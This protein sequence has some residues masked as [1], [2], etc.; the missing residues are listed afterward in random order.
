MKSTYFSALIFGAIVSMNVFSATFDQAAADSCMDDFDFNMGNLERQ[1]AKF[2][3]A[4]AENQPAEKLL[5]LMTGLNMYVYRLVDFAGIKLK[6]YGYKPVWWHPIQSIALTQLD[7]RKSGDV[8]RLEERAD[9]VLIDLKEIQ[10]ALRQTLARPGCVDDPACV[11]ETL[12]KME[13]IHSVA[14]RLFGFVN[15]LITEYV[16]DRFS[17]KIRSSR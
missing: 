13:Q 8:A 10:E 16:V 15:P 12:K 5:G 9:A 7:L 17:G 3:E 11:A 1:V 14:G 4:V 6:E 2:N